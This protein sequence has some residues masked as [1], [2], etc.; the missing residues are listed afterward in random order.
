MQTLRKQCEM[1]HM[2]DDESISTYF[3]KIVTLTNQM[4][5]CGETITGLQKIEKVL[6]SLT[7]DFDYIVVTIE[8]A[9]TLSEMKLEEL[10]ASLEAHEMRLKQRNSEREKVVEQ[11]LQS[12]FSKKAEKLKFRKHLADDEK[13]S[14]N[15]DSRKG[16]S[17]KYSGK[18]VD[19][20]DKQCYNCQGFGHFARDYRRRKVER[21]KESD[22]AQYARAGDSDSDDVLMMVN[23]HS[24]T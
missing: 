15:V 12:R 22:E 17:N 8:E 4:K 18:K 9:K 21:E 7:A 19:K 11:A 14:K 16:V 6:R 20:K 1:M 3:S 10:Q 2:K 23:S 13:S 24:N 5:A